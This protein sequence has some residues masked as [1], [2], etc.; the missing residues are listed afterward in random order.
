MKRHHSHKCVSATMRITLEKSIEKI[1][2]TSPRFDDGLTQDTLFDVSIFVVLFQ[3]K[4]LYEFNKVGKFLYGFMYTNSESSTY[5]CILDENFKCHDVEIPK[6]LSIDTIQHFV[7]E[8]KPYTS[9]GHIYYVEQMK[10]LL[11]L[12]DVYH[13]IEEAVKKVDNQK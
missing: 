12:V 6:D 7:R 8:N 5:W 11:K 1:L 2:K 3:R 9:G 13:I 4:K 10:T